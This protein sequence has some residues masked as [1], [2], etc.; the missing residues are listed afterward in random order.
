VKVWDMQT[1]R[2]L[3]TVSGDRNQIVAL[4]VSRNGRVMATG[5]LGQDISLMVYPLKVR[6]A[7]KDPA[8][9]DTE[10][11]APDLPEAVAEA[12]PPGPDEPDLSLL[13]GGEDVQA[14]AY[15]ALQGEDP[16]QALAKLQA[17]LNTLLRGGQYCQKSGA[18]E[19][20]ALQVLLLAPYDKA[21]YHALVITGIVQQDL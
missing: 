3:R 11:D 16:V 21:A 8:A 19:T 18:L 12:P 6:F 4:A 1:G 2:F 5:T 10:P 20:V 7:K 15:R 14:L 13:K 9:P 17:Q